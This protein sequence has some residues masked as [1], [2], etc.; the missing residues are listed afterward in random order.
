MLSELK[1]WLLYHEIPN[2]YYFSIIDD[3]REGFSLEV[4]VKWISSGNLKNLEI[5]S[6][7]LLYDLLTILEKEER[8]TSGI[9][10]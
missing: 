7:V 2:L 9:W 6:G 3:M 8:P 1:L 4:V 5:I 10:N